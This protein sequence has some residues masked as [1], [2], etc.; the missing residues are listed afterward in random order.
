MRLGLFRRRTHGAVIDRLH[1]EIMAAARQPALYLEHGVA[2]TFEGRFEILAAIATPT[3][4]RLAKLPAPGPELAQ[5]LTDMIFSR[6][7]DA[8]RETGTSDV[9]VPKKMK[10]MAAGWL[11]RRQA[12]AEALAASGDGALRAALSRNVY[13][14]E[15]APEDAAT[16]RLAA[17]VR[18]VDA[19]QANFGIDDYMKRPVPFPAAAGGIDGVIG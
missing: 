13:A 11:G 6:F 14:G 7:D 12:Y 3:V 2:D 18:R 1:G 8:L 17:Y 9:A 4:V 5:E 19:S 16:G 10:K 15:R